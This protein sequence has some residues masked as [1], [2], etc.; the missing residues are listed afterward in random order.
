MPAAIRAM[1]KFAGGEDILH[2]PEEAVSAAC[3]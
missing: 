3:S 1:R 2:G